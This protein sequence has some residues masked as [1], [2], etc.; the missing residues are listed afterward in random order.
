[1]LL[2]KLD[3]RTKYIFFLMNSVYYGFL[4]SL[5][6]GIVSSLFV[7][8]FDKGEF[9][10]YIRHFFLSYNSFLTGGLGFGLTYQVYKTQ[11][12]IPELIS[13]VFKN[14]DLD[15]ITQFNVHKSRF[16]SVNRSLGIVTIHI[17]ISFVLFYY[18]KFPFTN[19]IP[20]TFMVIFGC[21]LFGCGV[22]VGRKMFYVAQMLQTIENIE[23]SDDIFSENKLE[24]VSIYINV[25]T[26]F[27][28]IATW[29][30]VNSYYDGPFIYDSMFGESIR[31][32]MF[33]PAITALPVLVIFNYYPRVF[34][35]KLYTKSINNKLSLLEKSLKDKKKITEFEKIQYLA[36]VDKISKEELKYRLRLA[37]ND[38][39]MVIT[40][41]IMLI[42]LF[43]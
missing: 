32:F 4:I 40:I 5:G 20:E 14:Y 10:A 24:G 2:Q 23:F 34:I 16:Y 41:I 35:R 33:Y 18:A 1:M 36:E 9:S 15:R 25:I 21:S 8:L 39:P 17:V 13:N 22:Y 19:K 30:H 42:D 29:L 6:Y 31:I 3:K 7:Y 37:L 11:K 38:L 28:V 26:T 43:I 12:Y 27:T